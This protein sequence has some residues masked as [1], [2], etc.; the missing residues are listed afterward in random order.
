[1]IY[2]LGAFDG[3]HLGHRRLLARAAE[4]AAKAGTGWGVLTFDGHPRMLLNRD[5]FK[6]LFTAQERDGIAAALGVPRMEKIRFTRDFAALSPRDFIDFI[7]GEYPVDGL[8]IGE[9]FRF[10]KA[11]AGTPEVLAELCAS[12]GWTL[13][14]IP[15][16]RMRDKMVSSTETRGAVMAGEMERAAELLGYPFMI[17][18]MVERGDR[19]GRTLGFPTANIGT[20]EGKIYPPEGVYCALTFACGQWRSAALNIGSNPTFEGERKTRC[21]AHII[22]CDEELYD[23]PLLLFLVKKIRG[24]IKFSGAEQLVEQIKTDVST[25]ASAGKEYMAR[26]KGTLEKFTA[27]L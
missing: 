22:G 4:K 18:G 8:V 24:E 17:S 21:E 13:D 10:G 16:F 6:L 9:N 25:C 7:G 12:R 27:A 5:K 26:G 3:F 1:M 11:R 15:P 19:R 20:F 23:S 2:A 14:V